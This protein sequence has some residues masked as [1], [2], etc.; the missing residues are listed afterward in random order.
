MLK[1]TEA[2]VGFSEVPEEIALC[3]NISNCPIHCEG[4][5][6]PHLWE[7]IGTPLTKEELNALI[8][9]N[10]GITTVCLMGG[11]SNVAE[12]WAVAKYLR[13]NTFLKIGWYSGKK[14]LK[15]TP[16]EYFDYIKTGPYKKDLG[17]L[18]S[19]TTNQRFFE[20]KQGTNG[21]SL[22]D[23]TFKFRNNETDNKN[24]SAD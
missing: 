2:I 20:V 10:E 16:L 14:F 13:E 19:I 1:Y 8:E 11:D 4:C 5:H 24:K 6:S 18:D 15:D 22:K 3:I 7:D 12:L 9:K 23:I 21:T 17:G